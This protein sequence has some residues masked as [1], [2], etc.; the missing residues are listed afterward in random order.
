MQGETYFILLSSLGG[1][2]HIPYLPL[3]IR[4][5][6][7]S[8]TYPRTRRRCVACNHPVLLESMGRSFF[9]IRPYTFLDD[10]CVCMQCKSEDAMKKGRAVY[11]VRDSIRYV[12]RFCRIE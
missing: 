3:E 9:Q 2:G 12:L 6:I 5:H 11:V 10:E 4:Q 1:N 8:L 7:Y